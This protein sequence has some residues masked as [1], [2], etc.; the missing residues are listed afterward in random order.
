MTASQKPR[1]V[2]VNVIKYLKLSFGPANSYTRINLHC[3][4]TDGK[5]DHFMQSEPFT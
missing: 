3:H 2:E 5:V 4:S 1:N